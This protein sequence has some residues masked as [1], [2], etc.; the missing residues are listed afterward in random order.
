MDELITSKLIT[1]TVRQSVQECSTSHGQNSLTPT[2]DDLVIIWCYSAILD[3]KFV[4]YA[5]LRDKV[6]RCAS[7][8]VFC[9]IF[10]L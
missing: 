2:N 7:L 9:I 5:N 8:D 10:K 3:E 6:L 4:V 1:Y